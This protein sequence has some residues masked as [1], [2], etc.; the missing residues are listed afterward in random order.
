MTI[1]ITPEIATSTL[2]AAHHACAEMLGMKPVNKFADRPTAEKRTRQVLAMITDPTKR[3]PPFTS[4]AEEP[5]K[6]SVRAKDAPHP[7]IK[8]IRS[9]SGPEV[10][11]EAAKAR[12]ADDGPLHDKEVPASEATPGPTSDIFAFPTQRDGSKR[13]VVTDLLLASRE[14]FVPVTSL[15]KALYGSTDLQAEG[16]LMM[17]LK[18]VK[19]DITIN[20]VP[21]ELRKQKIGKVKSFGLFRVTP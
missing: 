11:A 13:K 16:A 1:T 2:V 12:A 17:V 9:E 20:K 6:G 21:V 5:M 19:V 8:A 18:G 14:Q 10:Q 7:A 3:P 4:T 15:L